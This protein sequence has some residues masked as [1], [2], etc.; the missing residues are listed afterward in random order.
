MPQLPNHQDPRSPDSMLHGYIHVSACMFV[1]LVALCM[2]S[3][4]CTCCACLRGLSH[5]PTCT[6]SSSIFRTLYSPCVSM[7]HRLICP[8]FPCAFLDRGGGGGGGETQYMLLHGRGGLLVSSRMVTT[9]NTRYVHV[10]IQAGSLR[11]RLESR[12]RCGSFNVSVWHLQHSEERETGKKVSSFMRVGSGTYKKCS[13]KT[14]TSDSSNH[15]STSFRLPPP[16]RTPPT[17]SQPYTSPP[18]RAQPFPPCHQR[19]S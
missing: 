14:T 9:I 11:P 19:D 2:N 3:H 17:Q 18:R 8:E 1:L 13:A 16:P 4:A 12:S 10:C 15:V 6:Y 7:N 5:V